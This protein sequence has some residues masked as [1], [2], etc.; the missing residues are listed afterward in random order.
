MSIPDIDQ[1]QLP[2]SMTWEELERLPEE[3]A[4]EI[5]LWAGRPVWVRRGPAEHQDCSG[6][7]WAVLRRCARQNLSIHPEPCWRASTETN[8]FFGVDGK[9]DFATPHFLV[10]RCLEREYQDLR[11]ADLLLVGEVLSPVNTARSGEARKARYAAAGIPWYWEVVLGRNPRHISAVRAY[12]LGI[13][14][15]LP[16]GI[17]PLHPANYLLAG[18]WTTADKGIDFDHPF[19]IHVP[20]AELEF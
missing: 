16:N 1:P 7:F 20:W 12:G 6:Q 9:S 14:G 15:H 18:E 13:G 5:E 19:P 10:Y 8:V 2:E 3:I 11:A 17:A 4:G